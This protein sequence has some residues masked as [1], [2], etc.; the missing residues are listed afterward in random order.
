MNPR[1]IKLFLTLLWLAAAIGLYFASG[2]VFGL[3]SLAC[4]CMAAFNF[5]RWVTMRTHITAR[6]PLRR[7]DRS[8][9]ETEPKPAFRFDE[10]PPEETGRQT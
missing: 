10:P 1:A 2:H 7:H 5:I 8:A 9:Q 4:L 3:F 6:L